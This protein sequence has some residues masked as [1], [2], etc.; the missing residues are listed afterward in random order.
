MTTARH[1]VALLQSHI[2]GDEDRFLSVAT[3]LAAHEARQGHGKLAQELR[4]LVDAAK[5]KSATVA[6]RGAGPVPLAQP[7]GELAGLLEARY[8]DVRL[9][10]MVLKPELDERLARV[11]REQRQQERLRARGLA[12]R[13]KL[14]LVGPPGA[15]KTMTAAALAGELKLPLFTV[16]YDGL[17]GKLMGETATRLRLVFDAVA[18]QRGVYFFDEFDAI[19][20]QRAGP[21]DVGEIRRVLNSFLQ[22]LEND[23]GPSLIVAATNH[24]ELLDKALYRRFD[25]VI[26]YD[27]PDP[28]VVQGILEARLATF[29]LKPIE[30]APVLESAAHLSQAEVARAADE[31]AKVAVLDGHDGVTTATLL[32]ALTERRAAIL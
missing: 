16:L 32:T 21:N 28:S 19:G 12:P 30:W 11:L 31:A 9:S 3:Q 23:D 7:K 5:G 20:A 17:I 18:M 10:S 26:S 1:I 29:D 6:R 24:P 4:E 27:L 15:G 22:F 14:L 13:R 25:D 2:D 8:S